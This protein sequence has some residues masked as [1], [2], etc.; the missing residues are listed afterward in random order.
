MQRL[1]SRLFS[2]NREYGQCAKLQ[3]TSVAGGSTLYAAQHRGSFRVFAFCL[4]SS[5]PIT[6]SD[7]RGH[8]SS[9]CNNYRDCM[10]YPSLGLLATLFSASLSA[11]VTC[12]VNQSGLQPQT[13]ISEANWKS[14]KLISYKCFILVITGLI[15]FI[16]LQFIVVCF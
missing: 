10:G 1:L 7:H 4:S 12:A 5:H 11:A 3:E 6:H 8:D 9:H 13:T 16:N 2:K 15:L 14:A